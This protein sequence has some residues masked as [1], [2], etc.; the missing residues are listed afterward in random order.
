MSPSSATEPRFTAEWGQ[1]PPVLLGRDTELAALGRGIEA[2]RRGDGALLTV[3]GSAGIGK[4]ALLRSALRAARE[5]GM[6]ALSATG[7]PLEAAFPFGVARQLFDPARRECGEEAWAEF[8]T[9]AARFSARALDE[10]A[11][12]VAD[13]REDPG[14]ATLHGLYWLSA[15]LALERPLLLAIDDA[16]WADRPSLRF[17]T[18][19]AR[20]LAARITGRAV[21]GSR[22]ESRRP[23]R[24]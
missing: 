10:R 20:R 4:T 9:G 23:R 8:S 18:H 13:P 11:L 19:L 21:S 17:L 1:A 6:R 3:E 5:G 12:E 16:Q 2:G 7:T 15:N 22:I 14:F 24:A